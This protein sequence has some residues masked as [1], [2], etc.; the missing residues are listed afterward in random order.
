MSALPALVSVDEYLRTVYEP[1]GDYVDGVVL[2]RNAGEKSHAKVQKRLVRYLEDHLS[3]VFRDPG[4]AGADFE[5]TL[6]RP[7]HL[8]DRRT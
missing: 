7:G 1:D 4:D 5:D 2:E 8:P 6:S 3:G